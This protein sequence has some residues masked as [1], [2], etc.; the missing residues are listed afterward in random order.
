M[1][2][3]RKLRD[4]YK[5]SFVPIGV[6]TIRNTVNQRIFV[7]GARNLP[8]AMNRHR[9]ELT[10]WAHR[11]AE[12]QADWKRFGAQA[13]SFDV[14]DEVRQSQDPA[15]DYDTELANLLAMWGE[16]LSVRGEQGYNLPVVNDPP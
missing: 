12:L 4:D 3:H 6:Y 16:E 13:F 11:N 5:Q 9:F 10:N 7:G 8:G 14:L 1:S 15:V 2:N